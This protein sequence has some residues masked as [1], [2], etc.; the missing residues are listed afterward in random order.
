MRSRI[1]LS[2]LPIL[3]FVLVSGCGTAK[4]C[5]VC[6]TTVNEG[7]G[8][9]DIIPVPEHNPTG[10]PGG[11][12]NSFDISVV[13]PLNHRF[14][15]S[16]RIGLDVVV[17]DTIR[18][19]AIDT[20]GG[21]NEVA[22]AGINASPCDPTIPFLVSAL[23]NPTRFGCRTAGF[24]I[25]GFGPNGLFG[26][27]SGAQCCASR[28]NGVNPLSCPCGIIVT[29]DGKTMFVGNSSS[30][31]V[32]FDLTTIDLTKS[33][34]TPPTVIANVPTGQSPDFDGPQ[35]VGPCIDSSQG[36]ALSDPTC[37]DL[38]ADE[39][40]YD[41]KDH[42]LLVANGDPGFPFVTL[43]NAADMVTRPVTSNPCPAAHAGPYGPTNFPTC[44]LGQIYY[45]GA[46]TNN[47]GVAVDNQIGT[48][49]GDFPCPDAST[50]APSGVSGTASTATGGRNVPC[51][52]GPILT[53]SGAFCD[54]AKPASSCSG[55]VSLAG[56]GGSAFN[57]NTGLFLVSN[58]SA[59]GDLTVGTI[60]VIDPRIG[61]SNGP[62]VVNSFVTLKCMPSGIT[63]GPG[64]NFLVG[65]ADHDGVAFPPN[66]YVIDGTSGAILA[67]IDKVGGVDETWYNPGDN[68][69]YVAARDMP[70]GPVM[71]IIDAKTNQWLENVATGS[72]SHSIAADPTNNHIFVPLQA[73]SLCTTQSANGCVAVYAQQ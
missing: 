38:R 39:M 73:G 27:F 71:G 37:G 10:A 12:F 7:Y 50:S 46:P 19:L 53:M 1:L 6:G 23:G 48:T 15:I 57:P 13:D 17:L 8:V 59:T 66:E 28:G 35:G 58:A 69:Y 24:Q 63:Q 31:V 36:R 51:H 25:P 29:A 55:A 3:L 5:P 26:G 16:D 64:N 67:T 9:I 33:P 22:E 30:T 32:V 56:I 11:P 65:C 21:A 14:Y 47:I 2:V 42:I 72:N 68:R 62:V 45:D 20:I 4:N 18:N 44:I 52:H 61:N 40:S 70:A 54:Q 60:D 43:I 34:P 49:A 41:E